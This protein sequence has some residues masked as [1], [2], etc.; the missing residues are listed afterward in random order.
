MTIIYMTLPVPTQKNLYVYLSIHIDVLS[1]HSLHDLGYMKAIIILALNYSPHRR[2]TNW[3]YKWLAHKKLGYCNAWHK[4]ILSEL[5]PHYTLFLKQKGEK[6]KNV[7]VCFT[8]ILKVWSHAVD[9]RPV[10]NHLSLKQERSRENSWCSVKCS[11][12]NSNLFQAILS[13]LCHFVVIKVFFLDWW[14]RLAPP[15]SW[16]V[17][18]NQDEAP[19]LKSSWVASALHS[20]LS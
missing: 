15:L 2:I 10:N 16:C 5:I 1:R 20:K 6:E 12:T 3:S 7:Y 19:P 9:R 11:K 13:N 17:C 18:S 14:Y 4:F 8:A